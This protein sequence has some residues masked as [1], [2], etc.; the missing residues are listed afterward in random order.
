MSGPK[1]FFWFDFFSCFLRISENFQF[2]IINLFFYLKMNRKKNQLFTSSKFIHIYF[3]RTMYV[4]NR[5]T[6]SAHTFR[7]FVAL[8]MANLSQ[9]WQLHHVHARFTTNEFLFQWSATWSEIGGPLGH[10]TSSNALFSKRR[11]AHWQTAGSR[12]LALF[13]TTALMDAL[14]PH[15]SVVA[16]T[17][18][19]A[20]EIAFKCGGNR[21]QPK[22]VRLT[23]RVP[24]GKEVELWISSL[25]PRGWT[26]CLYR[27]LI[28]PQH[29]GALDSQYLFLYIYE[30]LHEH[31]LAVVSYY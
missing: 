24:W 14:L 6:K 12:A 18:D 30:M 28:A 11:V 22:P 15:S 9:K 8:Q 25:S 29:E 2:L 19:L 17:A 1:Y 23:D 4:H 26:V 16:A 10:P 7:L 27:D 31:V 21:W 3:C 5:A 20:R 13:A